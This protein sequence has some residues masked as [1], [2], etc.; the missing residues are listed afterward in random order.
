MNRRNATLADAHKLYK[1]ISD[2]KTKL[3]SLFIQIDNEDDDL[4][5]K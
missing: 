5:K 2:I 1:D 3:D 4:E